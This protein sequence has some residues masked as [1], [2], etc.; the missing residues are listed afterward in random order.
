MKTEASN[1]SRFETL[2]DQVW[3]GALNKETTGISPGGGEEMKEAN[4][5]VKCEIKR[6]KLIQKKE[7]TGP[8]FHWQ[9]KIILERL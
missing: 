5:E 2:G 1:K 8:F 4:R 7:S 3:K 6:D 9:N